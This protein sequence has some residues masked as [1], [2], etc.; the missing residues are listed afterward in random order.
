MKK[1]LLITLII[2]LVSVLLAEDAE[3]FEYRLA[4][5]SLIFLPTAYTIPAGRV[6]FTNYQLLLFHFTFSPVDRLNLGAM[7]P[8]PMWWDFLDYFTPGFKYS[9]YRGDNFS[10]AVSAAY[11][12]E[13]QAYT[14]NH[15]L[16]IGKPDNSVHFMV[17]MTGRDDTDPNLLYGAGVRIALK[18]NTSLLCEFVTTNRS[19]DEDMNGV[20]S[21]GLRF[22][23]NR[24]SW[25]LGGSRTLREFDDELW[26]IP[27]VKVTGI[28]R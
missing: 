1:V 7:V 27:F 2:L 26:L 9:Y 11:I 10:M 18:P 17:G 8:F 5:Q 21:A 28:L 14:M 25:D 6:T 23:G 22:H 20:I 4:D 13:F 24:V 19:L 3:E 12:F 16:S 15:I